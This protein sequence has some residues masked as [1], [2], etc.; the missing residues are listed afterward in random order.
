MHTC[1]DFILIYYFCEIYKI[2]GYTAKSLLLNG[3]QQD[4]DMKQPFIAVKKKFHCIIMSTVENSVT[5]KISVCIAMQ[6]V[7][8]FR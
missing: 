8:N 1:L 3:R 2:A 5:K 6:S 7:W 4:A